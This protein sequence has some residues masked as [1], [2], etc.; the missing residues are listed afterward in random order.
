MTDA[1][2]RRSD[3]AVAGD[4]LS[5]LAQRLE[6]FAFRCQNDE[7]FSVIYIS[8]SI[9][10]TLGYPAGDFMHN[11]VRTLASV[12]LAEDSSHIDE[13]ISA[14]LEAKGSWGIEYRMRHRDGRELWVYEQGGGVFDADGNLLFLEGV[15]V[16]MQGRRAAELRDQAR[17]AR[18]TQASKHIVDEAADI[19]T[20]LR[21]LGMLAVN[22]RIEA[23]RAGET[24]R[25]FAVVAEEMKR[26]AED[27]AKMTTRIT[28]SLGT[29]RN[30][31]KD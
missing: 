12:I 11:T 17:L 15:A 24:G 13:A 30:V 31:F 16:L 22:A 28:A 18:M 23:A 9:E 20:A 3:S 10:K 25:G 4:T 5:S 6:G 7:H 29:M 19:L 14:A 27:T 21:S 1:I 8:P 2:S 26:L